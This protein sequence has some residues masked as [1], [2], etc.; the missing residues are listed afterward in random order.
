MVKT[1]EMNDAIDC[2]RGAGAQNVRPSMEQRDDVEFD[3][4]RPANLCNY[5]VRKIHQARG[6]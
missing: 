5:L 4:Q 3:G 1:T 2:K 6:H